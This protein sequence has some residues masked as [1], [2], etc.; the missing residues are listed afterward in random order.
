MRMAG[1]VTHITRCKSCQARIVWLMTA[2]TVEADDETYEHGRH[3]S[4][5]GTCPDA[6]KWR[7]KQ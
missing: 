2:D 1:D 5:F 6:D 3:V 7:R 4:H